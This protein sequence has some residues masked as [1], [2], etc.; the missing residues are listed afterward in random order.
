MQRFL[1]H[2][3]SFCLLPAALLAS[4]EGVLHGSGELWSL[5]RVIE[6]QAAHPDALY[7]R[8]A[9]Q[10]FYAYKYRGIMLKRPAVLVAGSSRTMK[11][12][13]GMFGDRA[14]AF[15][16]AGG[17]LN[18]ARDVHDFAETLPSSR[19]PSVLV[20]GIDLWWLNGGVAP[21]RDFR[22]E[23]DKDPGRTFDDHVIALRWLAGRPRSYVKE[24]IAPIRDAHPGFIGIGARAG[25]SGFRPDGSFA[26][27]LPVPTSPAGWRFVDREQP[28]IIERVIAASEGFQPADRL[29][30]ARLALLDTALARLEAR[31]VLVVGYLPPFSSA[32]LS[33]LRTDSRHARLWSDF[34]RRVPDLFR[35]HGFPVVDASDP[36]A[37]GMDDRAMIDGIHADETF[38][39]YVIRAMMADAR[40][41]AVL[42][43]AD[44]AVARALQS[45]RT[46]YWRADLGS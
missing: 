25:G 11:F 8:G 22:E 14:G 13:A 42:P 35:R 44:A 24:L 15:F 20:L 34:E 17:M 39:L 1:I 18:S 37:F 2:L 4:G 38:H 16:N 36:T 33:A 7:L 28:P 41:R 12:R 46:N 19:T 40:V 27:S 43:G 3:L 6:Y 29:S 31:R 21:L 5:G 23:I 26:S 32:V 10:V 9:D 45:P 30:P